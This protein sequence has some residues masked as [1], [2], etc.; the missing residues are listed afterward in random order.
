MVGQS[1]PASE[2]GNFGKALSETPPGFQGQSK[3]M[4]KV[5][6]SGSS[7]ENAKPDTL[8]SPELAQAKP[9]PRVLAGQVLQVGIG[10]ET[11]AEMISPL[12]GGGE[13]VWPV[14]RSAVFVTATSD[15]LTRIA[16]LA[17]EITAAAGAQSVRVTM[18]A[19]VLGRG[20]DLP[21]SGSQT[22]SGSEI[23]AALEKFGVSPDDLR[24]QPVPATLSKLA[25]TAQ[26]IVAGHNTI[27]LS[28]ALVMSLLLD[29]STKPEQVE[30]SLTYAGDRG[31][32]A[33]AMRDGW[34]NA[35]ARALL[36]NRFALNGNKPV[37]IGVSS[38][39]RTIVAALIVNV[40]KD[41]GK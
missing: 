29:T 25:E 17:Q 18:R 27:L 14:S 39:S 31:G 13:T 10:A 24:D 23:T 3:E 21:S 30:L 15:T 22:L 33:A 35:S 11:F 41:G 32:S 12:L 5:A 7:A 9:A 16:T 6:A 34:D 37:L 2:P 38:P 4:E 26:P 1:L 40:E 19:I 20:S 36:R 8:S 28:D